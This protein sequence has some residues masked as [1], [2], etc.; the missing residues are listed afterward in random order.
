MSLNILHV[1]KYYFPFQGGIETIIQDLCEGVAQKGHNTRVLCTGVSK[2]STIENIHG[3]EV[4]RF[5]Q[6]TQ[7][8][9]LP[10]SPKLWFAILKHAEWADIIH[11]HSPNPVC[12]MMCLL[13]P[14]KKRLISTHHSDIYKQSFFKLL[15]KPFWMLFKKRVDKFI[16]PTINHITFSDMINTESEKTEIIPFGLK[17]NELETEMAQ[18]L[19][20]KKLESYV[21]FVGRLVEYKGVRYLIEA[22]KSTQ[23]KLIIAGTGPDEL[24]LKQ[25]VMIDDDLSKRIFFTGRISSK[26]E[27]YSLY[28][29]AYCF[30]LPSIT[31]NENFGVVQLEAMAFAKTVITT[32]IKSGVPVVGIPGQT[33]L[34]VSPRSPQ[35]LSSAINKLLAAPALNKKMGQAGKDLFFKK[36][37]YSKMIES[38]VEL[39][40]RLVHAK[41]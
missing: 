29:N 38:H 35:E 37:T 14:F 16:V 9:S 7:L 8:N 2:R 19:K 28:E 33:S 24:K 4:Y 23:C 3:V 1:G 15:L 30:V 26:K 6:M 25:Q 41:K 36:Y 10:I 18:F 12:E 32:N 22:M 27:L 21:L 20:D 34:L 11:I 40:Q 39:Y 31:K 13:L 5:S 17:E